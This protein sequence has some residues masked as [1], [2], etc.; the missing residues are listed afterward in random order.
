MLDQ[1][2]AV[3]IIM[4]LGKSFRVGWGDG[5][6]EV[7]REK[8]ESRANSVHRGFPVRKISMSVNETCTAHLNLF[9]SANCLLMCACIY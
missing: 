3:N 7:K 8:T 4:A 2:P 1:W 6:M 9:M 5:W